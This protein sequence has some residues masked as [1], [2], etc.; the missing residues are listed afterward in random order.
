MIEAEV[1]NIICDVD[2]AGATDGTLSIA[3]TNAAPSATGLA[4]EANLEAVS[5][6]WDVTVTGE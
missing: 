2:V 3:G 6:G 4:C 1:N 5:R